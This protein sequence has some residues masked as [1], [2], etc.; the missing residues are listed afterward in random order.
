M[1]E[2]KNVDI[3][4]TFSGDQLQLVFLDGASKNFLFEIFIPLSSVVPLLPQ[5]V[6]AALLNQGLTFQNLRS[7][8]LVQKPSRWNSNRL[9]AAFVRT[10]GFA[11][12]IEIYCLSLSK[13]SREDIEILKDRNR[14]WDFLSKFRKVSW[15]EL[16][17]L[18]NSC[19]ITNI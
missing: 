5:R 4:I 12:P 18:Y 15:G 10:I 11:L 6:E 7:V 13:D 16:K 1:H 2:V 14:F 9:V 8:Y 17:A 3:Y 19:S